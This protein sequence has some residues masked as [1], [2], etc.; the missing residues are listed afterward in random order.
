MW[1]QLGTSVTD[2][3]FQSSKQSQWANWQEI[4]NH[5]HMPFSLNDPHCPHSKMATGDW[6]IAVAKQCSHMMLH[7]ITALLTSNPKYY[8]KWGLSV[9]N[10]LLTKY[11]L[12]KYFE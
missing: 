12:T 1:S 4:V 7:F 2:L 8:F 10:L 3:D 11:W 9:T 6:G 5:D